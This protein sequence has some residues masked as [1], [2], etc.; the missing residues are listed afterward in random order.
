[1]V[2]QLFDNLPKNLPKKRKKILVLVWKN[3]LDNYV[4]KVNKLPTYPPTQST[5]QPTTLV[6]S[7]R[8][9]VSPGRYD[10]GESSVAGPYEGKKRERGLSNNKIGNKF[11]HIFLE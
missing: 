6:W 7:F 10:E 5:N 3:Q 8:F 9:E 2:T 4:P 1:M 11:S